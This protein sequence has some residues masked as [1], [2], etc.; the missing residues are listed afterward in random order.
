MIPCLEEEYRE[1]IYQAFRHTNDRHPE[2]FWEMV[3]SITEFY[4]FRRRQIPTL[5]K[6]DPRNACS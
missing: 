3:E 2:Q 4:L 6:G 5:P 1:D